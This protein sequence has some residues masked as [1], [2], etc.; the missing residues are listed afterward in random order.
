MAV[1]TVRGSGDSGYLLDIGADS[2]VNSNIKDLSCYVSEPTTVTITSGNQVI[3]P[4]YG[5]LIMP[6]L[7]KGLEHLPGAILLLS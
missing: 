2:H 5:R 6:S 4:G 7:D 3:S 1:N